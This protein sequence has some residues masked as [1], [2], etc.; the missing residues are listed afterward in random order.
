MFSHNNCDYLL[1]DKMCS[2][3][4]CMLKFQIPVP[5][6]VTVFGDR[7]FKEIIKVMGLNGGALIHVTVFG[8]K[9]FE[10]VT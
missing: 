1:W 4:F 10:K 2:P 5:Q 3:K 9:D 7:T 8:D 6:N